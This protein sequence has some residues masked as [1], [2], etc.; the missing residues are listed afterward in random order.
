MLQNH[1]ILPWAYRSKELGLTNR[2]TADMKTALEITEK[3]KKIFPQ[4]P[5]LGDFALFGYGVNNK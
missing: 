3:L 4:D 5:S 1:K 2:N